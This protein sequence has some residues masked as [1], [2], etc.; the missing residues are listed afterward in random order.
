MLCA[1]QNLSSTFVR[2]ICSDRRRVIQVKVRSESDAAL[3]YDS[4]RVA[5][6]LAVFAIAKRFENSRVD[7]VIDAL[8]G[9]VGECKPKC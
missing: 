7:I 3:G 2:D 5:D 6:W 9:S 1:I 4:V 8:A